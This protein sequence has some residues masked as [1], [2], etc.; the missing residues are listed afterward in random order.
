MGPQKSEGRP[1]F[2]STLLPARH[3]S[4]AVPGPGRLNKLERLHLPRLPPQRRHRKR[5]PHRTLPRIHPP[6]HPLP[7]YRMDLRPGGRTDAGA[8]TSNRRKRNHFFWKIGRKAGYADDFG[9]VFE[10]VAEPVLAG[11]MLNDWADL[12]HATISVTN[13]PASSLLI[14]IDY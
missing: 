9:G 14:K 10:L 11:V 4:L 13:K 2:T 12:N 7:L 6:R 1:L 5:R 3:P 8:P